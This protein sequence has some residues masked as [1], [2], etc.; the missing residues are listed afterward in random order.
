MSDQAS[1]QL[2][3]Q[4]SAEAAA[5]VKVLRLEPGDVLMVKVG[6]R[7][8]SEGHSWIPGQRELE[9]IRD[10]L[11]LVVPEG[12]KCLVSH[13]GVEY[14]IVRDLPQADRVLVQSIPETP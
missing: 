4:A 8:L 9:S 12:V 11:G 2:A 10:D 14:E 13:F 6:V 5:Q 1:A 3:A 7:D